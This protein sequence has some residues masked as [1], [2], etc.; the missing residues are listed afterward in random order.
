MI[1]Q[2]FKVMKIK[3]YGVV[4]D[5]IE[6]KEGDCII[7]TNTGSIILNWGGHGSMEWWKKIIGSVGKRL[8]GITLIELVDEVE[9]LAC[10]ALGYDYNNW[11]NIHCKDVSTIIYLEVTKWV[12]GYKANTNKYSKEDMGNLWQFIVNGAKEIMLSGSTSVGSFEDYIK[13]L[14]KQVIPTEV[15]LEM[16]GCSGICNKIAHDYSDEV[17]VCLSG[18]EEQE[19]KITN[20]KTNTITAVNYKI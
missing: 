4:I 17:E 18:C 7:N 11:V 16:E 9:K 5:K 13:S 12:K 15:E 14:K 3:D 6:I 10:N 2:T 1:T 20:K 19:V 8:D